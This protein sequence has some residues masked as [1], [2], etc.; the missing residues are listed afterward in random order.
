VRG[1]YEQGIGAQPMIIMPEQVTAIR[2]RNLVGV[3]GIWGD[4]REC[5]S[6]R[7]PVVRPTMG[8]GRKVPL[9]SVEEGRGRHESAEP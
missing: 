7:S 4:S 6:L 1:P 2:E 8:G 9:R 5:S 3:V